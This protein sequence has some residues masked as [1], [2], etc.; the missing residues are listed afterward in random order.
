MITARLACSCFAAMDTDEQTQHN[1]H[2][3]NRE[4]ERERER[5][6]ACLLIR[7]TAQVFRDHIITELSKVHMLT[8]NAIP[9]RF[10][11]TT[12]S[13]SFPKF[14]SY[15]TSPSRQTRR[16]LAL[17]FKGCCTR[18][19]RPA[20]APSAGTSAGRLTATLVDPLSAAV[21]SS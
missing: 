15:C 1:A 7:K 3:Y 9:P 4:R 12:S 19:A 14:T 6:C 2:T 18:T 11:V 8:Y 10:F 16:T 20:A 5:T 21:A 13:R 17:R